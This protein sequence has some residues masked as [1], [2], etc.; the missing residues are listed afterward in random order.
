[1]ADA[2]RLTQEFAKMVR[3]LEGEKL[4]WWLE[5]ADA[6]EAAVMRRFAKGLKKEL[7]AVR[8]GLT[9]SWS[10]G[11]VEGFIHKLKLITVVCWSRICGLGSLEIALFNPNKCA[12]I[13]PQVKLSRIGIGPFLRD[14]QT[15]DKALDVRQGELRIVAKP[16]PGSLL[17]GYAAPR[18]METPGGFMARFAGLAYGAPRSDS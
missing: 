1:L 16:S 7:A 18:V 11:P 12:L 3:R 9:E 15:T 10:S 2:Y 13:Q 8:A 4:D 6:S 17:M 14:Q 5:E